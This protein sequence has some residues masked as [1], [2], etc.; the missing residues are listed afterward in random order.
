M[1]VTAVDNRDLS[2][3]HSKSPIKCN[4]ILQTHA[5]KDTKEVDDDV[6]RLMRRSTIANGT[7]RSINRI[8]MCAI[9]LSNHFVKIRLGARMYTN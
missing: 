3:L 9:V 7:L 6:P 5:I 2:N 4:N 1:A 8:C